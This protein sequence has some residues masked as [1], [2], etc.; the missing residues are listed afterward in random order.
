[1]TLS[2]QLCCSEREAWNTAAKLRLAEITLLVDLGCAA[3]DRYVLACHKSCIHEVFNRQ[4]DV[5]WPSRSV[6]RM[7]V[8]ILVGI[9]LDPSASC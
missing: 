2:P 6:C 9:L 1:M 7:V 5:H 3:V 4:R 8:F